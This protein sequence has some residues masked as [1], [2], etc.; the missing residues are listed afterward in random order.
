[1]VQR[2]DEL[3]AVMNHS[4]VFGQD[5]YATIK[6]QFVELAKKDETIASLKQ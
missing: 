6:L 1:M 3:N 5:S 2:V 4:R